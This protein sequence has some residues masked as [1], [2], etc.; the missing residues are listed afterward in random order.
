M[1]AL[2]LSGC[3]CI[4]VSFWQLAHEVPMA[5]SRSADEDDEQDDNRPRRKR[6]RGGTLSRVVPYRNVM[7]LA[8][9]Y[10]G[11]GGLISILGSIAL[12]KAFGESVRWALV[13]GFVL[14]G[15]LALLAAVL[16]I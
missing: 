3:Y 15:L 7:A 4:D 10:C 13:L 12:L 9:Y 6:S 16:G 11:F 14:G 1:L 8:A 5:K 2:R